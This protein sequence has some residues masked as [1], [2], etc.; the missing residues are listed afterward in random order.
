VAPCGTRAKRL[1]VKLTLV[2]QTRRKEPPLPFNGPPPQIV[3]VVPSMSMMA[4]CRSLSL[5]KPELRALA[6]KTVEFPILA[7][8]LHRPANLPVS[9]DREKERESQHTHMHSIPKHI[10]APRPRQ[11]HRSSIL[12]G[13]STDQQIRPPRIRP[14][15]TTRRSIR[16]GIIDTRVAIPAVE[17][18][19]CPVCGFHERGRFRDARVGDA[20]V[21]EEGH[22]C[23][24][25][26]VAIR[27]DGLKEDGRGDDGGDGVA[28]D[29]AVAEGVAVDLEAEK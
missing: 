11:I 8:F 6:W 21:V 16:H 7:Q 25:E 2:S 1:P 19:I 17:E 28:A 14:I 29:A 13:H 20:I 10:R 12:P 27:G 9:R 23:P 15:D 18:D 5:L 3:T 24:E 26:G 22:R 4:V